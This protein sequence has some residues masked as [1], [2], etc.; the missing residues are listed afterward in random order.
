MSPEA[1][2]ETISALDRANFHRFLGGTTLIIAGLI[3]LIILLL[4]RRQKR[5]PA[6]VWLFACAL[7][8]GGW[9]LANLRVYS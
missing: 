3:L 8:L 5:M 9:M 4:R 2:A 1:E 7:L 6:L